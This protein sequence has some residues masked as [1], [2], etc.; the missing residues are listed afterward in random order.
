M[1]TALRPADPFFSCFVTP[2]ATGGPSPT[3]P[4]PETLTNPFV[5]K[6]HYPKLPLFRK[7]IISSVYAA[8]QTA[9]LTGP[10]VHLITPPRPG[11]GRNAQRRAPAAVSRV[12]TPPNMTS[13]L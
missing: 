6:T 3:L 10:L 1:R 2:P 11:A 5:D 9:G 12:I 13:L 7:I 4:P 8:A